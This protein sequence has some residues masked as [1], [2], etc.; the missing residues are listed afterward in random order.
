LARELGVTSKVVLQKCRA[1]GLEIKNHM[2]ALSAG[3]T[4]TIREWFT[5][6]EAG[7]TT[8]VET[9]EH[10]D[11][12]SAR[13]EARKRRRRKQAEQDQQ[14]ETAEPAQQAVAQ[15][16]APAAQVAQEAQVQAVAEAQAE[17]EAQAPAIEAPASDQPAPETEPADVEPP[18]APAETPAPDESAPT[19]AP[20]PP[21]EPAQATEPAPP[22]ETEPPAEPSVEPPAEP[23]PAE[24]TEVATEAPPEQPAEAVSAGEAAAT[25]DQQ[26]STDQ[27]DQDEE[28][29]Q[30][31]G[32]QVVPKP[33]QLKGPRVVR[34]E[35][36]DYVSRPTPRSRGPRLRPGSGQGPGPQGPPTETP[37]RGGSDGSR[38]ES[39][40]KSNKKRSPRRRSG[41]SADSG[42]KIREWRN[43]DLLERSERLQAAGAGLR[44]HRPNVS[45]RRKVGGQGGKTGKVEIEEPI[46]VK[47]LSSA[48]G[49]KSAELIKRLMREGSLVTVNQVISRD[50]AE[51]AVA[52]Y[53]VELVVKEA[54]TAEDELMDR[55]DQRE[56]GDLTARAPVVTFLGHVDHGKTSLLDRIRQSSVAPGE[57]GGITQHIGAYRLDKGDSHVVFLDTPGHEAFTA[58]RARGARMTDVVVLVVAADDGVMPQTVEAINHAKAAKVPIVVALNKIDVPNANPNRAMAQLAENELQPR[59]WGGDTEVIQTSAETGQGIDDLVETLSLEAELLELK[60]EVDSPANGYVIEAEKDPSLGV[61]AR[62]L[63]MSGTMSVGDDILAGQGCGRVRQIVDDK[64]RS[65]ESAGPS[66]PVEV[67]GLDAVPQAGDR[68][69]VT[70]DV[71]EARRVAEDRR[72]RARTESLA[73]TPKRSVESLFDR[74]EAG[75]TNKVSLIIKADVQGS[76]EA[77]I[78]SLEKLN[79]DEVEVGILHRGVG[80]ITTGDVTLADASGAMI[81]GFGVVADPAARSLAEEKKVPVRLYR[82]IYDV[83]EDIRKVME[84]GLAPEIKEET[85]GRAEVRQVFKISRLGTIAGCFVL[86]GIA[87]RNAKVRI[88]RNNIVIEDERSLDSLKRFKDDAREVR[89]GMECGLKIAGYD[90]VKEG[91]ILEFYQQVEVARTL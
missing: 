8:A 49:I 17:P 36:P 56:K 24:A 40:K 16:Q 47:D 64:G 85:L 58:M 63:V 80:G 48:T 61:V 71:D 26:A 37:S 34:V 73:A 46:T 54:K 23:A 44:R 68:F 7:Q 87:K 50:L 28:D 18:E 21:A 78:G 84:E 88:T 19:P 11:L 77:L 52:D 14:A 33:A 90:D 62:L 4:A 86:D 41:R 38:R 6:H 25:D 53:D 30:P 12:E 81:I 69:F 75:E 83:I 51:L 60:A 66:T 29:I 65:V 67:T 27:G 31:A 5:E 82:V 76:I 89:S 57:A 32:P 3:Q 45:Q 72:Q 74:F 70:E 55:L 59:E 91:D 15:Q 35:K 2:S 79:T 20:E 22:A 1:E 9:A 10:V 13:A 43:Q 42:E 39:G